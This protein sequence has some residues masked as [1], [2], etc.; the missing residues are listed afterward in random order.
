MKAPVAFLIFNRPDCTARVFEA[1]R[2]ARPPVLLVVADGPRP[3]HPGEA[4]RCAATRR[5]V[6]EGVDWPCRILRNYA[7]TNLGCRRR[8]S[9]G[10]TWVFEQVEEAI[11]LEDDCLPHATFFGY[12]E[13]L[14]TYYRTDTRVM[15]VCGSCF[16]EGKSDTSPSP[17]TFS[18]YCFIWGWATW[19]RA[20]SYYDVN[21][22]A[23]PALRERGALSEVFEDRAVAAHW[24][25][26]FDQTHAGEVDT[27]DHQWSLACLAQNGLSILP[28]VNL[29]DNIG[30]GADATHTAGDRWAPGLHPE[31]IALP[32]SHPPEMLRAAAADRWRERQFLVSPTRWALAVRKLARLFRSVGAL[33]QK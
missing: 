2:A 14:L 18:R 24:S 31:G 11:I 21:M 13:E 6:D 4:E 27:W 22:S 33:M 29:I 28:S 23:W 1:I 16:L 3:D 26:V 17:Y 9:S 12:C 10:L 19:R 7:D 20:W 15:A 25:R 32:L 8:V 30:F 5:I